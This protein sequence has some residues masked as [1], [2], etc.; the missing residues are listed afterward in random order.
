MKHPW[1]VWAGFT[2]CAALL[3]G[4]L[5]WLSGRALELDRAEAAAR[6]QALLEEN[7]RLA[8]WR[9]DS[10]LAALVARENVYPFAGENTPSAAPGPDVRLHF[11]F[12]PGGRLTSPEMTRVHGGPKSHQTGDVPATLHRLREILDPAAF[13]SLLPAPEQVLVPP[14]VA[15]ANSTA[16]PQQQFADPQSP[17]Q[18]ALRN[19]SEFQA[20]SQLLQQNTVA[21]QMLQSLQRR[22][23]EQDT[24]PATPVG[25]GVLTPVWIGNEL[26]LGRK[27]AAAGGWRLQGAWLDWPALCQQLHDSIHDLLPAAD[28]VPANPDDAASDADSYRLATLPVRLVPGTLPPAPGQPAFSPLK[29]S[30]AVAWASLA[31]TILIAAGLLRGVLALSERRAAFVSAVTHELRTPL[32]TFRLYAEMLAEGM[33]PTEAERKTYLDTL[34]VEAGRLTHLVENVLAYAR[35]E[36]GAPRNRLAS[37]SVDELLRQSLPRLQERAAQAGMELQLEL[38]DAGSAT[39]RTDPAAVEQILFNL[40]DNACKYARDGKQIR[41]QAAVANRQAH[42]S[43]IDSGPGIPPRERRRLFRPFHKSASDAA[44]SAPGVGLGLSLSRRLARQMG[45]NLS[46]AA[47]P[48]GGSH[49]VLTLPASR[50][51]VSRE[52]FLRTCKSCFT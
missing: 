38:G 12:A 36:K 34:R 45:G 33:V 19:A 16:A 32:T 37:V 11:D 52:T 14:L 9:M 28:L 40:V 43:I 13:A 50:N 25:G 2:L 48:Q 4:A 46:L 39:V 51:P 49:F 29:I 42:I 1:R 8:L 44:H 18:Q 10:A 26:F 22:Q 20:R 24:K 15:S 31:L 23:P 27:L 30:L 3:A 6:A 35:L 41:I 17:R 21:N 7:A 5:A 47:S